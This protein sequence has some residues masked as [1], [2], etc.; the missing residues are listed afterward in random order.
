MRREG[1]GI[2]GI[3]PEG[4]AADIGLQ[5]ADVILVLSYTWCLKDC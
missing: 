4:P 3:T 1:V 2:S 5:P